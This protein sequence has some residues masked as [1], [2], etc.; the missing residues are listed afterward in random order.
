MHTIVQGLRTTT[1]PR[2]AAN[3]ILVGAF[4]AATALGA[5]VRIPL[6]GTMVPFTLQTFFV[7]FC[8]LVLGAN[9]GMAAQ[10]IYIVAGVI[11]MPVFTNLGAGIG[12]FAGPTGG[13]LV[14]FFVAAAA[15]GMLSRGRGAAG[16]FLAALAGTLIVLTMGTLHLWVVLKASPWNAMMLGFA[17]FIIG[18]CIKAAAAAWAAWEMKKRGI[19]AD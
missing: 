5:Y 2:S 10:A 12:Y 7:V 9:R 14:G 13:Y 16:H 6:P 19:L 15:A 11:G 3:V 17:P 8:G 1:L 4:A 18:D